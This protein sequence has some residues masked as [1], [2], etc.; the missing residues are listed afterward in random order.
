MN[1]KVDWLWIG[2]IANLTML[3]MIKVTYK[4]NVLKNSIIQEMCGY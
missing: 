2:R 4:L 3:T 1:Q